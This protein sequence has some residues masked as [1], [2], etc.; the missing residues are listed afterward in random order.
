[1]GKA[2]SVLVTGG[3]GFIGSHLAG[4]LVEEGYR[5]RVLDNWASGRRE[6]LARWLGEIELVEG[7]ICDAEL[8]RR[9][10]RGA[11]WVFHLAAL[12]SVPLSL[13]R[14][15]EF[16]QVNIGGT[17]N[18]LKASADARVERF[19]F[20]SSS[21]CYGASPELPKREEL[22]AKPLSPYGLSK[23]VGEQYCQLFSESFGLETVSLRY[24]NVFGPRQALRSH[25]ASVVPAF[26]T[27]LLEGQPPTIDGDGE[28]TR[29]FT[30]VA[31]AVE[32]TVRAARAG[33]AGVSGEVFN[34]G[35]GE[36]HSVK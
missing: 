23:L 8:V 3:G 17:V 9:A 12:A 1:M 10:V 28:Q 22:P 7:D 33:G 16:A 14:P 19:V 18:L 11:R 26:I 36:R 2:D 6:N 30:Y 31:N 20:A 13:E 27:A 25:Y 32:A 15:V 4:R 35:S 34:V 29:D 5:V 21:S 24:F